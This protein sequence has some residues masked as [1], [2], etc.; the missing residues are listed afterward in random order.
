[1]SQV[2]PTDPLAQ[3]S[4]TAKYWTK[5]SATIRK[6]FAPLTDALI[7]DAAIVPGQS[8][9]DVAAGA[10]E[11]SL[12]IAEEVGPSGSVMC[13]DAIAEMVEAAS[14]EAGKRELKNI[15]FRQCTADS[16]PFPENSFD[17]VVSRLGAMFFP[18]PQAAFREMLRA[19]KPGGTLAFAVW[20]QSDLNPFCHVITDVLSRHVEAAPVDPGAPG[21]FRFAEPGKLAATLADA[22]AVDVRERVL[23]FDIAAP[24]SAS[25]FW[26]LRSDTSETLRTKLKTLSDGERARI[27]EELIASVKEFFPNNQMNFPAQML[28][29]TGK[30]PG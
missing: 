6:M 8:V 13:T 1:M 4:D 21:A 9:L 30:K 12:T 5:H 28:I 17:T 10:G 20:H 15:E 2:Q 3:W 24:I 25:D 11:P 26:Q 18:D 7:A 29:V 27:A 22:G 14:I 16:L 23:K 19:A